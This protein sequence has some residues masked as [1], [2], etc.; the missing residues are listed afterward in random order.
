[1]ATKKNLPHN[2]FILPRPGVEPETSGMKSICD[3]HLRTRH[4]GWLDVAV[5]STDLTRSMYLLYVGDAI[6]TTILQAGV[7]L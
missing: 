3:T 5:H 2:F 1:M 7:T 4:G 6:I